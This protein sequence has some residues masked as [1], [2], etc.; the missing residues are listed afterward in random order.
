LAVPWPA[1]KRREGGD[2]GEGEMKREGVGSSRLIRLT[3]I[4]VNKQ[5]VDIFWI[6]LTDYRLRISR[7]ATVLA[8]YKKGQVD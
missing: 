3:L 6:G 1:A 4:T 8:D 7:L 2:F 5:R